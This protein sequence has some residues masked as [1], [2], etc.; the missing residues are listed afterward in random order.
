[1]KRFDINNADLQSVEKRPFQLSLDGHF[2][3]TEALITRPTPPTI[4]QSPNS[5][6]CYAMTARDFPGRR[7]TP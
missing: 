2:R 7:T 3:Q 4:H 6:E 1:M 5:T